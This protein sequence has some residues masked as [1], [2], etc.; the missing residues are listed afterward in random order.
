[1]YLKKIINIKRGPTIPFNYM[2]IPIKFLHVD[3]KYYD[4]IDTISDI[5]CDVLD[6]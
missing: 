4:R 6:E 2:E 1:M 3:D 5:L